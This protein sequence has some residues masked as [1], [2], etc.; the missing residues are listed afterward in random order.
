LYRG[1]QRLVVASDNGICSFSVQ[2]S[3]YFKNLAL[4]K[5]DRL[6]I[7]IFS[8]SNLW[9]LGVEHQSAVFFWPKF[10]G[11]AQIFDVFCVFLK[12]LALFNLTFWLACEQLRRA[13][14]I[15]ASIILTMTST[16]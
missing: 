16:D 1:W 2:V 5:L 13:T 9:A 3:T 10:E 14:F 4:F 7:F 12:E 6:A 11:C 8:G 15:P